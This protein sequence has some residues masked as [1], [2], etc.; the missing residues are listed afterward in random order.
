MASHKRLAFLLLTSSLFTVALLYSWRVQYAPRSE[1]TDIPATPPPPIFYANVTTSQG[2]FL[3]R[4]SSRYP[5]ILEEF[6]G[7]PYALPPT[8]DRRFR[9]PTPVN[10][11][12][13]T[14]DVTKPAS[15]CLSGPN[16]QGQ[17]EACLHLNMYRPKGTGSTSDKLPVLVHVHGGAFNFGSAGDREIASLVG[18]SQ[19]PL[20]AITFEYRLGALGF[21]SS[22][23]MAEEGALNLGLKDQKLLFKW[24]QENISSFG[25]DPDNVTLMGPSAGAHSVG[26]LVMAIA[27]SYLIG[28]HLMNHDGSPP[29]FSK[30][31]IESGGPTARAVYKYDNALHE[32]QFSEFLDKLGLS[33]TPRAKV[34]SEL[35][36][37]PATDIKAASQEI[38]ESY[39]PSLRW[40][41]QPCVDGPGANSIIPIPPIQAYL[42]NTYHHIPVLVGYNTNEGSLFVPKG[43]DS[44]AS[45]ID[46]FHVLLPDLSVQDLSK[47]DSLYPNPEFK[48]NSPYAFDNVALGVGNQYRRLDKSYADFAYIGPVRQLAYFASGEHSH[49]DSISNPT[50]PAPV[51]LYEYAVNSSVLR[52]AAHGD[53]Y[54]FPVS[55]PKLMR[56]SKTIKE[57]SGLMHAYWTSFIISPVGDPN[58]IPGRYPNRTKWPEYHGGKG[59]RHKI[60]FGRGNDE[61]AG[62]KRKGVAVEIEEDRKEAHE[63]DAFTFWSERVGLWEG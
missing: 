23:L 36:R 16:D 35:R 27:T 1:P 42:N 7:I 32:T 46:F 18:W 63:R 9:P 37:L 53:Q 62:G 33:N 12:S 34:L 47:L 26:L 52:G 28:H 20:I 13:A 4:Q 29:L 15:R 45:F 61:I 55:A 22:K 6:L 41:F 56:K 10:P 44:A 30:A 25:G 17:S 11:S 8:G 31:I 14:F 39:N 3:G 48:R 49:K 59:K 43:L 24:V 2:T 19:E 51:Y 50:T 54:P 40:P 21:L 58:A 5:Q 38:Y 57:I 60:T